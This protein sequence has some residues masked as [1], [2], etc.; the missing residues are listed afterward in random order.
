VLWDK[1]SATL[2]RQAELI[3]DRRQERL[4]IC[5]VP[6]DGNILSSAE[7]RLIEHRPSQDVFDQSR[8]IG[9]R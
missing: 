4:L 6:A 1:G 3:L 7:S 5:V 9:Q 2:Q 8:Q